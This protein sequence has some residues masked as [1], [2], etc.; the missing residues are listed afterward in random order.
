MA[1]LDEYVRVLKLTR[2]PKKEEFIMIAKIT[3][4]GMIIIGI[5][6]TIITLIGDTIGLGV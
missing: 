5:I 6:G 4:A 1:K 3:G 2:R